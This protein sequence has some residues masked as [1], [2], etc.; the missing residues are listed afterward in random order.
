[1][2]DDFF[3]RHEDYMVMASFYEGRRD[4]SVEELYQAF[5]GRL[6]REMETSEEGKPSIGIK[7]QNPSEWAEVGAQCKQTGQR[8]GFA[9]S[10]TCD[11][12]RFMEYIGTTPNTKAK[13]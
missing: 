1:M 10:P 3:K 11:C 6:L 2:D 12:I 13:P 7:L 4:F 8:S 9:C 5:K